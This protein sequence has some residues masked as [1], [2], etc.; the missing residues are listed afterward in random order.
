MS[1]EEESSEKKMRITKE[2]WMS[3]TERQKSD[4]IRLNNAVLE[5]LIADGMTDAAVAFREEAGLT[6]MELDLDSIERR[7]GVL[8]RIRK[9]ETPEVLEILASEISNDESL[10]FELHNHTLVELIRRGESMRALE[11]ARKYMRSIVD[12]CDDEDDQ[13]D[14]DEKREKTTFFTAQERQERRSRF[15][16]TMGLLAFE[17]PETSSPD[18]SLFDQVERERIANL[19]NRAMLKKEP[20]LRKIMKLLD[21]TQRQVLD[22]TKHLPVLFNVRASDLERCWIRDTEAESEKMDEDEDAMEESENV[23]DS[24]SRRLVRFLGT[25][26]E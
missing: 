9:G 24:D 13:E 16:R 5:Y 14:G 12:T 23:D 18:S 4:S 7:R 22:K 21:W 11:Y 17:N 15:E 10:A 6:D 8:E 25:S 19:V 1:S 2:D 26:F 3:R 20:E